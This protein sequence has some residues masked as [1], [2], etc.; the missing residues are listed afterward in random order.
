MSELLKEIATEAAKVH[1]STLQ[2]KNIRVHMRR[3]SVR[4]EPEMWDALHEIAALEGCSIHH[5][6]TAVHDS[7]GD[8]TSFTAA[9]RVFLMVYY[10][11]AALAGKQ[12]SL[13]QR[14]LKAGFDDNRE[15]AQS[16][17]GLNHDA[18]RQAVSSF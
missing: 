6:C 13:V 14:K 2:S 11:S 16:R 4:L 10:R 17:N 5:I 18:R 8:K 15:S 9:L 1:V 7:R 12:V 3:T